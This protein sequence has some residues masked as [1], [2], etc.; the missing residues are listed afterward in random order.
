M[1]KPEVPDFGPATVLVNGYGVRYGLVG[2]SLEEQVWATLEEAAWRD[3]TSRSKLVEELVV[4]YLHD[5]FPTR[6]LRTRE[7]ARYNLPPGELDPR[8][9]PSDDTGLKPG[10]RHYE[11]DEQHWRRGHR[12][13]DPKQP[14]VKCP[15]HETYREDCPSCENAALETAVEEA[16]Q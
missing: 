11:H 5:R 13:G 12:Q 10:A 16:L 1:T 6:T 15:L 7:E 9:A 2:F 4:A 8:D 3:R 14:V